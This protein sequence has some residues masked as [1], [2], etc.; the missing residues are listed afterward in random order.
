[1]SLLQNHIIYRINIDGFFWSGL[2]DYQDGNNLLERNREYSRK[3]A[4]IRIG[5]AIDEKGNILKSQS[6]N[7]EYFFVT[8]LTKDG[9]EKLTE[10]PPFEISLKDAL[11]SLDS[12]ISD[13]QY[14]MHHMRFG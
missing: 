11:A 5:P 2:K 6:K 1:M 13:I 10:K 4:P 7:L 12:D 8:Y 3:K 14:S 9:I